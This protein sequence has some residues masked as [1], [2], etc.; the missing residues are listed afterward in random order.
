MSDFSAVAYAIFRQEGSLDKNGNWITSSVGYRNNNPGNLMYAGQPGATPLPSRDPQMQGSGTNVVYARFDTL[1]DGIAATQRQLA[2][3]ASR[4]QTLG[5]RLWSWATRNKQAYV[6]NVSSWLG[7]DP[8]T[9]LSD[10]DVGA[11]G[12]FP[13]VQAK[14]TRTPGPIRPGSWDGEK[15]SAPGRPLPRGSALPPSRSA[16]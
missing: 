4:G 13:K 8:N 3:D 10:L 9:P 14:T 6:D 7:V 5:Q 11:A 1:E 16:R 12:N 15:R 2:L